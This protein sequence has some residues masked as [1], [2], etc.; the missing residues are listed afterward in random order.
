MFRPIYISEKEI[1]LLTLQTKAQILKH[2]EIYT[3]ICKKGDK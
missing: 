3:E 1:P 2:N